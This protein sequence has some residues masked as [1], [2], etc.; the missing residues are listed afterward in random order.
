[1]LFQDAV[2]DYETIL[3]L[4]KAGSRNFVKTHKEETIGL[5]GEALSLF[6]L[7]TS[8]SPDVRPNA[9]EILK[10]KF[11]DQCRG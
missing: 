9:D 1:M 10:H 11:F 7:L 2:P 8:R 6:Y 3:K 4:L 5:T